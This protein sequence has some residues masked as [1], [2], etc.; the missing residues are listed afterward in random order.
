MVTRLGRTILWCMVVSGLALGALPAR[1]GEDAHAHAAPAQ[2]EHGRCLVC[3]VL[4][5]EAED[6]PVRAKHTHEGKE[7]GFC[8]AKC[9]QEFAADPEAFLPP[10]FPRQAPGFALTTLAGQPVSLD[11]LRGGVTL[12]DFW[13]TWC[14][15][16]R[17]SM[18]ELQ[19]LHERYA[20]KGFRV[21]GVSIDEKADAKV[22][23]YVAAQ[24]Y[25]YPIAIDAAKPPAWQRYRVKSVPA[26]FLL[27]GEGRIVAQWTGR[28]PVASEVEAQVKGLLGLE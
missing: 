14:A 23:K 17:K 22:R 15:P 7:Y 3:A 24:K 6:E 11:S 20:D 4:H 25:T 19:A 18:P 5:G 16:C 9:A 12:L 10:V 27:D 28:S 13:A 8:S 21:L 1:A 2:A 26:A